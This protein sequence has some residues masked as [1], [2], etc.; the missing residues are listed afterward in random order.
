MEKNNLR[1]KSRVLMFKRMDVN[2]L[3]PNFNLAQLT[4]RVTKLIS[5]ILII[6]HWKGGAK[7]L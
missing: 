2:I 1:H 5:V 7:M 3:V 6:M 4:M